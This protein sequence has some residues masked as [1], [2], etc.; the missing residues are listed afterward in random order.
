MTA[1]LGHRDVACGRV[2]SR[3]AFVVFDS[4]QSANGK[5]R[6]LGTGGNSN[7][8]VSRDLYEFSIRYR[9]IIMA[10]LAV[11]LMMRM[12]DLSA[13]IKLATARIDF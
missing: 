10:G 13:G 9:Y 12:L 7:W 8:P 11:L 4:P 3:S 5:F 2:C 1:C 6:M